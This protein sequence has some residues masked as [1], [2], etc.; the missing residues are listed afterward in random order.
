LLPSKRNAAHILLNCSENILALLANII[1]TINKRFEFNVVLGF[2]LTLAL[3]FVLG[4]Y[5][6]QNNRI[7][8]DTSHWVNHTQEVLYQSEQLLLTLT[9]IEAQ[10]RG[11]CLTDQVEFLVAYTQS[12]DRI[13]MQVVTLLSLTKDN[14]RQ[15]KRLLKIQQLI[16][17]KIAFCDQTIAL[18]KVDSQQSMVLITSLKGKQL[19]D[20]IKQTFSEFLVEEKTLLKYRTIENEKQIT[21][22]NILFILTLSITGLILVVLFYM[23]Y[24]NLRARKKAEEE[25]VSASKAI[26]DLYDNAPCGYHSLN[27]DGRF[28]NIN[29]TMLNWLGYQRDEVIGKKKI[30]DVITPE[31]LKV[32]QTNFPIFKQQGFINNLEVFFVRRDGSLLPG[33]VNSSA[34]YDSKGIFVKS[35]SSTFD[36]TQQKED[37]EKIIL[38]NQELEAFTYTVSHDLRSPLRSITGYAQILEEDYS[39]VLD[40]EGQRIVEVI[41]NSS[42][43]MAQLIDDL[44][45]FARLGRK[46][47]SLHYLDMNKLIE[48]VLHELSEEEQQRTMEIDVQHLHPCH[49]D[50]NMIKQVWFNL[51]SNAIKYSQNKNNTHIEIG[52][53]TMENEVCYFVKDNGAGFDMKYVHKLFDVFQRL[54]RINEFE[55]TGVGLAIVKRIV[56]RH[57]GRVWAEAQLDQGA[58]FYFSIPN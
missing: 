5:S 28:L 42:K 38:L 30:S 57:G 15:N 21:K 55:G 46:D 20:A 31:S 17:E 35:R 47:L 13:T 56:T 14:P 24:I 1:N 8:L 32:F 19:M 37:N 36:N 3:V 22:F 25:L 6:Y 23:I 10:Q 4:I 18:R 52:S 7:Q 43:R 49:G 33:I 53:F 54:H 39:D 51:I 26:Q 11:Y 27:G 50:L 45:S 58:T 41:I 44:L 2:I 34:I 48:R 12:K 29:Q 9:D 40:E 16:R